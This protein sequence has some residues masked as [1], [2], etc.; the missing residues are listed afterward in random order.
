MT[1]DLISNLFL[2]YALDKWLEQNY[3]EVKLVRY[4][5]DMVIHC[6]TKEQAEQ[7]LQAIKE[8][9]SDVKLKLNEKKTQ[10]VYC[11]D[12]KR[13]E[14]HERVQFEFLGFSYQPR[15]GKSQYKAKKIFTAFTVEI[16][17]GNQ[18]KIREEIKTLINW[19][20][21]T[22]EIKEISQKLNSLLRGWI[23]Y[24]GAYSKRKLRQSLQK[25]DDRLKQWIQAKYKI[26]GTR[27][28]SKH[29][30][31]LK[32]SNPKMFYHWEATGYS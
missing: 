15:P 13:K 29:L 4:A 17:Q 5:D 2:H 14:K 21:T 18:K 28:A 12:Y 3:G 10:I 20:N 24:Y 22:V 16:S 6:T 8:R 7:L 32:K 30:S 9:L 26:K 31:E 23:N 11:K 25:V 27:K 19:R 1:S